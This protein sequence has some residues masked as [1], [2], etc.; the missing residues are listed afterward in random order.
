M[1]GSRPC[2]RGARRHPGAP[3]PR[4][5]HGQ[6]AAGHPADRP[7]RGQPLS[8]RGHDRGRRRLRRRGRDD[9][10]RRARADPRRRQEPR[11]RDRGDRAR[12]TTRRSSPRARRWRG[13]AAARQQL[14]A[15]AFARTA[16]YDAAIARWFA[17]RAGRER[18]PSA[19]G[20]ERD[21]RS[22]S[23]RYGE[24]P[25]QQAAFYVTDRQ[26]GIGAA[27]QVQGKELSYNNLP[28]PMPRSSWSPSSQSRPSRS[29]STPIPAAWRSA[30]SLARPTRRRWPAIRSAPMAASWRSTAPWTS[31]TAEQITELFTEVVIAPDAAATRAPAGRQAEPA[32][33]A[34]RRARRRRTS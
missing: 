2:T 5:A 14:A 24:N 1:A 31:A 26:R 23:L 4:C 3:R 10:H 22:S 8:L 16:A 21:A 29:S 6:I 18:C 30:E 12:R 20:R 17:G 32:A 28:T 25:H 7:G 34:D 15:K 27:E 11:G 19:A 9:R 33:A 13:T